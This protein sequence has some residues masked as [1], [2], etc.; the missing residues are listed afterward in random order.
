MGVGGFLAGASVVAM[1]CASSTA[2]AQDAG[3]TP[4]DAATSSSSNAAATIVVTG[5]RL[6]TDGSETPIPVTAVGAQELNQMSAGPL[7]DGVS[8]LPQ[9]FGNQTTSSVQIS[10]VGGTGWFARGGYGNLNLRGL[11]I[12]RTLT[13]LDGHRVISSGP[14]GGVD[15]NVIPDA[16]ISSVETVT[17]GASAAYGTD[18]V[19]G[20]VNFKLD[21]R[22]NGLVAKAQA[23]ASGRG[24]AGNYKASLTFGT[25]IG[26][27]LHLI[28][29]GEYE[30]Q[31]GIHNYNG[32]NWYQ[33]YGV[34]NGQVVPDVVSASSSFNGIIFAPGTPL[35]GKEFLP[36]GSGITPFVRSSVSSGL[37]GTPPALQSI[38]NGGSGQDLAG[39]LFTILPDSSRNSIY[40][41]ADYDAGGGVK[42][43]AQY[44]R[45]EN[46]T[47]RY[48]DPTGSFNG[49]PTTL[50]IFQD[51]AFLPATVRQTMIDNNIKSF[52]LR[53]MGSLADLATHNWLKDDSVMNSLS[54]GLTW[55]IASGG[56]F[57]GWQMDLNYQYGTNRRDAFQSGTLV[58]NIFASVDAVKDPNGNIVCR[59]SL[60]GN[61]FPGCVPINLFGQGNASQAAINYVT[62]FVPGQTITTP[63]FYADTGYARGDTMTY[64][65]GLYKEN[66]TTM[67][68]H[69]AEF[70]M[71]GDVAHDWAGTI[72][73]AFGGSFRSDSIHQL[74][75]DPSNPPSDSVSGHPVLCNGQAPGLR[76][77][78]GPDCANSVGV[79]YSKVSNLE[80]S[81][82]VKEAFAE[83][84]VPLLPDSG[85][86]NS[87]NLDV[88]GRWANY[89][90][91]GTVWAYKAGLKTMVGR[92]LLLRGT[93]SRDVRAANLS[94]RFDKTGGAATVN[95]NGAPITVTT[96]S[97]GNPNVLPEKADTWTVGAVLKPG[98][99]PG[100]S[101]SADYYD[102]RIKG[103]IG[104]LGPQ[105]VLDNCVTN[106]LLCNLVS[107]DSTTGAPI[108]IG[109]L[110][111][112][113]NEDRVRGLDVEANYNTTPKIFGGD[114]ALGVRAFA[115]WLFESTETLGNGVSVDRAGQ[116]GYQQSN[117][118]PYALPHFK[119]TGNL[120]YRNGGFTSFLQGRYIGPGK[121]EN[122]LPDSALNHV[123]SA[124]YLDWR[125]SYD[126]KTGSGSDFQIFA[127]VTNL[128][129]KSPP[130][131]PYYSVF[132]AHTYQANSTLFDLVGRR[133]T[134]GVKVKM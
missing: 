51:N 21:H 60:Y 134:M 120:T 122:A 7:I 96:Y 71:T 118:I 1:M 114:E 42:V 9:F 44:I 49:T 125:L 17:G 87:A 85:F 20:V 86:V 2:S 79:Q 77:V 59:V 30:K 54:A 121:Q 58:S 13:L 83:V 8:Q 108:L 99:L 116:T 16:M 4:A 55:D 26:E 111:I 23:G 89:S 94:E 75:Y 10:G 101:L 127:M 102:I 104:Q 29:S 72:S 52:T 100:F 110:Y 64:T 82:N 11:G 3:K 40:A 126:I 50:T 35:Q 74:V 119:L 31:N 84:Q 70:S 91:S 25:N 15:I 27:R 47:F 107:F 73:A 62:Q 93:Y 32:R 36:D 106:N 90:G 123:D 88:S 14:F 39:Q 68:E 105:A 78:S 76:G 132:G 103:A 81:I 12:N 128:T 18:A 34:V 98:F 5:S 41:R 67:R 113:V 45:G 129:D 6:R 28:V 97:G 112:N 95:F 69:V 130:L 37:T 22:F 124:F 63:I 48:N 43:H 92:S 133:Y 33:A 131:T 80:G 115:T 109:N 46:R 38:A 66:V 24:D 65:T 56:L 19:A 117:G 61:A 53:K 57:D